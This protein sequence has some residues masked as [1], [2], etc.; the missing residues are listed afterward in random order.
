M[1]KKEKKK[2]KKK[3]KQ[4]KDTP[5]GKNQEEVPKAPESLADMLFKPQIDVSQF[6]LDDLFKNKQVSENLVQ[7][8]VPDSLKMTPNELY[9]LIKSIATKRY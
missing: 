7:I 5:S 2:L 4:T 9:S 6:S 8:P 1:T 3:G